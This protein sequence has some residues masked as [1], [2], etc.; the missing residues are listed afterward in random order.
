[1]CSK[2]TDLAV[3]LGFWEAILEEFELAPLIDRHT[4]SG[5]ARLD[6]SEAKSCPTHHEGDFFLSVLK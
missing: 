1:M 5:A 2:W 6:M 3:Q 4:K